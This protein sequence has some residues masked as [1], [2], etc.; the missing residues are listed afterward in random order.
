M[1]DVEK[2]HSDWWRGYDVL[3]Y[4]LQWPGVTRASEPTVPCG[5]RL[6]CWF[7]ISIFI[8]NGMVG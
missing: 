4:V 8:L 3:N 7:N 5:H 2:S 6:S 1:C